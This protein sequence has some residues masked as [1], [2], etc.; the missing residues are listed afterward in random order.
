[1]IANIVASLVLC[2]SSEPQVGPLDGFLANYGSIS[3]EIE[4]E[5]VF[6][7]ADYGIVAN[8]DVANL[9]NVVTLGN[10]PFVKKGT[11][12][13][14]GKAERYEFQAPNGYKETRALPD[15]RLA[16]VEV[17]PTMELLVDG[18]R[19]AHH[20]LGSSLLRLEQT[21]NSAM[22]LGAY[23][24]FRLSMEVF[25]NSLKK[26]FPDSVPSRSLEIR[27]GHPLELEVYRRHRGAK[28]LIVEVYYDPNL[29]YL[30]RYARRVSLNEQDDAKITEH[31]LTGFRQ[32]A[33]GG[34]VPTGWLEAHFQ[35]HNF[36]GKYPAYR[37][38]EPFRDI[39]RTNFLQFRTIGIRDLDRPVAFTSS[40]RAIRSI[41]AQGGTRSLKATYDSITLDD[42]E[43]IAGRLHTHPAP[44]VPLPNIDM[45]ALHEFDSPPRRRSWYISGVAVGLFLLFGALVYK[46]KRRRISTLLLLGIFIV[47]QPGCGSS[48]RPHYGLV[49]EFSPSKLVY[50]TSESF[51]PVTLILKNTGNRPI[52]ILDVDGGCSC[53][54]IDPKVLP[55]LLNLGGVLELPVRIQ[56]SKGYNT[57][58]MRFNVSTDQGKMSVPTSLAAMP[59]HVISPSTIVNTELSLEDDWTFEFAHREIFAEGSAK[60][61]CGVEVSPKLRIEML[62][63]Q[64]GAV[65]D[66][67]GLSY[68]DTFYRAYLN[69][70]QIGTQKESLSLRTEGFV[71]P[72]VEIP[73]IWRRLPFLSSI[74]DRVALGQ[75]PVR[76]F[77]RCR[78]EGVELARVYSA[79]KG[80]KAVVVST[81]ELLVSLGE[82]PPHVIDG[83]IEVGTT[84][85]G[86]PPLKVHVVRYASPLANQ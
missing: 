1:M 7:K 63:Q 80:V 84:A 73:V 14:D 85:E 15:G 25:P 39:G 67:P 66:Y 36:S 61:N 9:K 82:N 11:W 58:L 6:G 86:R 29:N 59:D 45:D 64:S 37:S 57:N 26:Q 38:G 16:E 28:S 8:L 83:S 4:Y 43:R 75:R 69:D 17:I 5:A 48:Q 30:V 55:H 24:P 74:P 41:D 71:K 23:S 78:D 20:I 49:G 47:T 12:S 42:A 52:R 21:D 22:V 31:F 51:F 46:S 10:P 3:V 53:R 35:V 81:S 27:G 70:R 44:P 62:R 76:V 77:L 68:R 60:P 32:C 54:R 50:R 34:F 72:A 40:V 18:E 33:K 56:G 65:A 2:A 19:A 13:C 79:P